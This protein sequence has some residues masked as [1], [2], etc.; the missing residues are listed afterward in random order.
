MTAHVTVTV[1]GKP[2]VVTVYQKSKS[3]WIVAGQ[4][5][6][7]QI[8]VTDSGYNAAIKRWREAATDPCP[9]PLLLRRPGLLAR[10]RRGILVSGREREHSSS[11]V[12]RRIRPLPSSGLPSFCREESLACDLEPSP[13]Y[14]SRRGSP[15]TGTTKDRSS[16]SASF[17]QHGAGTAWLQRQSI[18][19]IR[20]DSRGRTAPPQLWAARSWARS[21]S[22]RE[23]PQ[24]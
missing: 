15:G 23:R 22:L 21:C 24:R 11:R 8:Q 13:E 6:D 9:V 5:K 18:K 19:G 10:R 4:Y 1:W 12:R 7:K 16:R 14:R 3:E 20:S 2:H 17:S